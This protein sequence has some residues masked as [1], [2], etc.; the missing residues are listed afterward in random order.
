MEITAWKVD[1]LQASFWFRFEF[2]SLW[3]HL[4]CNSKS[5]KVIDTTCRC[6]KDLV[7]RLQKQISSSAG[8]MYNAFPEPV[9]CHRDKA[10]FGLS[11]DTLVNLRLSWDHWF[12]PPPPFFQTSFT[13]YLSRSHDFVITI[14]RRCCRSKL[15]AYFHEKFRLKEYFLAFAG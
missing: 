11:C 14:T 1:V 15:F 7:D 10:R 12:T 3:I 8:L 5:M 9:F 13:G 6:Y 2:F 4:M